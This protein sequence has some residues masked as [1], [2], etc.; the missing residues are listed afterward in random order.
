M[1]AFI[2]VTALF[3]VWGFVTS[4]IDGLAPA[5]RAIFQLSYT[6]QMLT[7]F[8]F[9]LAYGA[10]SL[11]AAALLARMGAPNAIILALSAMVLG[12]LVAMLG[13]TVDS[14]P[15]ILLALFVIASGITLLQV[16][17]NPL[18][19]TLGDP[20]RSHFRLTLSQAFNSLGT[21]LGPLVAS[22]L[23]LRGGLFEAG[24][25][26][27]MTPRDRAISLRNIDHQFELIAVLVLALGV[28]IWSVR[29]RLQGTQARQPGGGNL[30]SAFRSGWGLF[31]AF[32]IFLYVGS[33]V[34]A[35]TIMVNFL[36]Q[37]V[38]LGVSPARAAQLLGIVF[39]GGATIG[40]FCASPL[41]RAV[42]A[43]PVL[44]T[45]AIIDI[46]LCLF[47]TQSAGHPAAVAALALGFFNS[48]MFPTIFT[49]TLLRSKA[50]TASVSGL[51]CTAI[52]GGAF[53][54]PLVGLVADKVSLSAAFVVPLVGYVGIAVFAIFEREAETATPVQAIAAPS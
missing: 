13:A 34:G 47:V 28:F 23:L 49:L 2:P 39:W 45:F 38:I 53:V 43:G 41:L 48:V 8:A 9:F 40:R 30:L 1:T 7:Q 6:E 20:R 19:A 26:T 15:V 54:P 10:V 31:G 11:P 25:A 37:P 51:L 52:V 46:L 33:E 29:S 18:S 42:P 36:A 21:V 4:V 24:G 3:L 50:S 27:A 22:L 12:C 16:A 35:S 32:A 44:G 17:A 14:Y 5:A